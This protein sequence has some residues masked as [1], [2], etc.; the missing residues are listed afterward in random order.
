MAAPQTPLPGTDEVHERRLFDGVFSPCIDLIADELVLATLYYD[1]KPECAFASV[2]VEN[3][4]G[5]IERIAGVEA[6][7][8]EDEVGWCLQF[9]D[10]SRLVQV[11][12]RMPRSWEAQALGTAWVLLA[13][14][15]DERGLWEPEP[16]FRLWHAIDEPDDGIAA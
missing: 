14:R 16:D 11:I 12:C 6:G 3:E 2:D 13:A 10:E 7:L 5:E 9:T 8:D 4:A 15:V 1:A